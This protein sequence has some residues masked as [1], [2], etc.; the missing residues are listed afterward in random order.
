MVGKTF[1]QPDG[2]TPEPK[3]NLKVLVASA[4]KTERAESDVDLLIVGSVGLEELSPVLHELENRLARELNAVC[5]SLNE[6]RDKLRSNNH[7]LT[8]VMKAPRFS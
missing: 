7:F 6:F 8:S 3:S 4:G 2:A 5:Y 1:V